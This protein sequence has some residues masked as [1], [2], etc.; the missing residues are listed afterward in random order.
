MT[1]NDMNRQNALEYR[2]LLKIADNV[3]RESVFPEGK[4]TRSPEISMGYSKA[5]ASL[6]GGKCAVPHL[7]AAEQTEPGIGP[8]PPAQDRDKM[9]QLLRAV[10]LGGGGAV[11][12][13]AIGAMIP[14]RKKR[15]SRM[16]TGAMLGGAA[17][18]SLGL[19]ARPQSTALPR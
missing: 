12:G 19:L 4:R 7:K 11:A 13:G 14:G 6:T 8:A 18:G 10:V 17:G 2:S 16:L 15:K 1:T 3:I 5:L 9:L